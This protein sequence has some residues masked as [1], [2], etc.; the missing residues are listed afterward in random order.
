MKNSD[1]I[2]IY[3]FNRLDYFEQIGRSRFYRN[4]DYITKNPYKQSSILDFDIFNM[5][6]SWEEVLYPFNVRNFF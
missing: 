1:I 2:K 5:N 6:L 3:K 4:S